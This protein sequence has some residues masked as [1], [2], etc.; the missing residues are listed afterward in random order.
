MEEKGN[1]AKQTE[2]LVVQE[3]GVL[4]EKLMMKGRWSKQVLTTT[5][6]TPKIR[7]TW[8]GGR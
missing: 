3:I 1:V 4:K 7:L 2:E 6:S 8:G 5:R